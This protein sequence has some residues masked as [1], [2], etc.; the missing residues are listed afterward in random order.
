M[1]II[2]ES[3]Y[4]KFTFIEI[5]MSLLIASVEHAMETA[6]DHYISDRRMKKLSSKISDVLSYMINSSVFLSFSYMMSGNK[7]KNV[8]LS[9]NKIIAELVFCGIMSNFINNNAFSEE[10]FS[11][12]YKML[13][14][15]CPRS[16]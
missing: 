15:R 13:S 6:V 5:S 14:Y 12:N 7:W 10:H 4:E 2:P 16:F 8:D 1:S 9:L 11:L 3:H